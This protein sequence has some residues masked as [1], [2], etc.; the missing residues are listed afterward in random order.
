MLSQINPGTTNTRDIQWTR[1]F[2]VQVNGWHD[3]TYVCR[4][5]GAKCLLIG[6][7]RDFYHPCSFHCGVVVK[8][9]Y[10]G[11]PHHEQYKSFKK[12]AHI[13]T[14]GGIILS[15]PFPITWLRFRTSIPP[16]HASSILCLHVQTKSKQRSSVVMWGVSCVRCTVDPENEWEEAIAC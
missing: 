2:A 6:Y 4:E 13:Q 15:S 7:L 5:N 8:P 16:E 12:T 1:Y 14:W 11:F 3:H 10:K 9:E